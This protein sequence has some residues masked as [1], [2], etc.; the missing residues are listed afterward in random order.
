[1]Q[2]EL[3][4]TKLPEPFYEVQDLTKPRQPRLDHKTMDRNTLNKL[5]RDFEKEEGEKY[6]TALAELL[7]NCPLDAIEPLWKMKEKTFFSDKKKKDVYL[8]LGEIGTDKVAKLFTRSRYL[9]GDE[10]FHILI[11]S[12]KV[13]SPLTLEWLVENANPYYKLPANIMAVNIIKNIN[14]PEGIAALVNGSNFIFMESQVVDSNEESFFDKYKR[15]EK[16]EEKRISDNLAVGTLLAGLKGIGEYYQ[17]KASKIQCSGFITAPFL[18]LDI[19]LADKTNIL[20]AFQSH[21]YRMNAVLSLCD[22]WGYSY[23]DNCWAG[24]QSRKKKGEA[25]FLV[26][27]YYKKGLEPASAESYFKSVLSSRLNANEQQMMAIYLVDA[28]LHGEGES[29]KVKYQS[30]IERLV[31]HKEPV[32]AKSIAA[33]LFYADFRPLIPKVLTERFCLE[34]VP[35]VVFSARIANNSDSIRFLEGNQRFQDEVTKWENFY[36]NVSAAYEES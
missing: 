8:I 4:S 18:P 13:N 23:L 27:C 29:L 1:M 19:L 11:A 36:S 5:L 14:K 22:R 30:Q 28:L 7:E 32:I 2:G 15:L 9:I 26:G 31:D 10:I 21:R 12:A 3:R 34:L 6:D 24:S 20:K 16:G 25:C 35:A 33:S 17:N